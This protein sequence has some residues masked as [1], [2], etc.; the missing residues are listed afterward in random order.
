MSKSIKE[1][2]QVHEIIDGHSPYPSQKVGEQVW[3]NKIDTCHKCKNDGWVDTKKTSKCP[4]I[5]YYQVTDK[6]MAVK[7]DH[8]SIVKECE[9][10]GEC[11]DEDSSSM[12]DGNEE[13]SPD[14]QDLR[15]ELDFMEQPNEPLNEDHKVEDKRNDDDEFRYAISK[16]ER[17]TMWLQEDNLE[18][19]KGVPEDY[20]RSVNLFQSR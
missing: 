5:D 16:E 10:E 9:E 11:K 8:F 14:D 15:E 19:R 17:N 7:V 4:H 18:E 20:F 3:F 2:N 13:K 1:W 12:A 6:E